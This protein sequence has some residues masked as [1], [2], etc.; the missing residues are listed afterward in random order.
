MTIPIADLLQSADERIEKNMKLVSQKDTDYTQQ[1]TTHWF[2]QG[3]PIGINSNDVSPIEL[4]GEDH[5]EGVYTHLFTERTILR[6]TVTA[7]DWPDITYKIN[8]N[9]YRTGEFSEISN[10]DIN[11]LVVGCSYSFGIGL[12]EKDLYHTHIGNF[13]SGQFQQAQGFPPKSAKIWNVSVPGYSNDA[14]TRLLY[15]FI[16]IIN[17]SFVIVQWTMPY[18]R[19]YVEENNA[20]KRILSNHPVY[21]QDRSPAYKSFFQLHNKF[22]DQYLWEKNLVMC[23]ALCQSANVPLIYDN[24]ENFPCIDFAR[25]N[26][27]PGP[28]AHKA[29][30]ARLWKQ[31]LEFTV[32]EDQ[33]NDQYNKFLEYLDSI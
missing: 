32:Y 14:I 15:R 29:F 6:S 2:G 12:P 21:Y 30:A 18:R 13:L 5:V 4:P 26:E 10:D 11:V 24:W 20:L 25:D 27:H 23:M 19:E 31:Y 22:Y 33:L 9:G 1:D 7:K 8:S 16:P 17:P 3:I 28:N